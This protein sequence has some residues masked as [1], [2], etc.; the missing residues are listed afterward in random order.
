MTNKHIKKCSKQLV[1]KKMPVK[2]IMRYNFMPMSM[3]I[4]RKTG[5]EKYWWQCGEIGTLKH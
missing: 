4:L 5:N 1:I 2:T 3:G